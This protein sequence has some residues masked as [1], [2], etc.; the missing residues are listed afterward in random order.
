MIFYKINEKHASI[1][2]AIKQEKKNT[3]S[4]NES[5]TIDSC[6][7]EN[8]THSGTTNQFFSRHPGHEN[9]ISLKRQTLIFEIEKHFCSLIAQNGPEWVL[10][11]IRNATAKKS[12]NSRVQLRM[13][14]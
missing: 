5:R 14:E 13:P 7:L 2:L 6:C 12:Y 9:W 1:S 8:C 10:T 3:G 11:Q 4:R